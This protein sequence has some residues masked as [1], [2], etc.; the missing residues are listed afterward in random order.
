MQWSTNYHNIFGSKAEVG[1][2]KAKR[3]HDTHSEFFEFG[4]TLRE[5]LNLLSAAKKSEESRP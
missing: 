1:I 5:A 3:F 4:M 2:M